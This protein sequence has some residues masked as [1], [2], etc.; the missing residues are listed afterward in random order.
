MPIVDSHMNV[1]SLNVARYPLDAGLKC[2]PLFAPIEQARVTLGIHGVDIGVLM[3]PLPYLWDHSYLLDALSQY[4]DRFIGVAHLNPDD[5]SSLEELKSFC[6]AGIQ[7]IQLYGSIL[8]ESLSAQS[9]L[10]L[11]DQA[12][13]MDAVVCLQICLAHIP[14]V[15]Q[16]ASILPEVTFIVN[17]DA[18]AVSYPEGWAHIL[19][20]SQF[21]NVFL[22]LSH[23]SKS[24]PENT[25]AS[26]LS[27]AIARNAVDSFGADRLL[28]GSNFPAALT[29]GGYQGALDF[30]RTGIPSLNDADLSALL[31]GTASNIWRLPSG[32]S[33]A[34]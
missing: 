30:V 34:T 10:K 6:S 23:F 8:G 28:W 26:S 12:A 3:Q 4:G 17:H 33:E 13:S 15:E 20:L 21:G 16:L 9:T 1:F 19:T 5:P 24:Y 29:Q 22:G 32:C 25:A 14:A 18:T 7:G 11:C 2:D 31:G 27:P